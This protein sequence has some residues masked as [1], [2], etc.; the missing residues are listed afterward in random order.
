LKLNFD[1]NPARFG[2]QRPGSALWLM[3]AVSLIV[4]LVWTLLPMR[5]VMDL[6]VEGGPVETVTLLAYI[7]AVVLVPVLKVPGDGKLLRFSLAWVVLFFAARESDLHRVF[8]NTSLLKL[9]FYSNDHALVY[10]AIGLTVLVTTVFCLGVLVAQKRRLLDWNAK[11]AHQITFVVFVLALVVAKVFDRGINLLKEGYGI[12]FGQSIE[13]LVLGF[14]EGYEFALPLL[15][16]L[17]LYQRYRSA[18]LH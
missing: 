7:V 16:V 9:S 3:A 6:F 5:T 12:E 4:L 15:I 10:K 14:E 17:G 13:T 18:R 11:R 8:D 2:A 1:S